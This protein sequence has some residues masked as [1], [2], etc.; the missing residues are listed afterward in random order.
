MYFNVIY[1]KIIYMNTT[2]FPLCHI[3]SDTEF[4][5]VICKQNVNKKT[6][7]FLIIMLT[8]SCLYDRISLKIYKRESVPVC[9]VPLRI[10]LLLGIG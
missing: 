3:K 9:K 7:F 5:I 1:M 4:I 2:V 6:G 8:N 10:Y